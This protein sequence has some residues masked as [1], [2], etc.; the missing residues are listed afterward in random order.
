[1]PHAQVHV[2][3]TGAPKRS[4]TAMRKASSVSR[5]HRLSDGRAASQSPAP[6]AEQPF[7]LATSVSELSLA[8]NIIFFCCKTGLYH[9]FCWCGVVLKNASER[10]LL[11]FQRSKALFRKT[12]GES[13][14]VSRA[15]ACFVAKTDAK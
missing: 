4:P 9:D 7:S 8:D 15:T 5:R 11:A 3:R 14:E 10:P 12:E 13:V 1:M 6:G 2:V